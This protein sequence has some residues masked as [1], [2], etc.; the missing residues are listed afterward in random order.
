[1]GVAELLAQRMTVAW[2]SGTVLT[3]RQIIVPPRFVENGKASTLYRA[4]DS[5]CGQLD[6]NGIAELC[7]TLPWVFLVEN[8]DNAKPNRRKMWATHARLPKNCLYVPIG[9]CV[10]SCYRIVEAATPKVGTF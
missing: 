1:M 10:H 7:K 6:L 2:W 9:C 4:V 3:Q 8:P 5:G